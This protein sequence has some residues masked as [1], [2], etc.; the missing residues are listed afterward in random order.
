LTDVEYDPLEM[1]TSWE[2]FE[3]DHKNKT[4]P[5]DQVEWT[6]EYHIVNTLSE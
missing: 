3:Q 1:A 5:C 2:T 6:S 4:I